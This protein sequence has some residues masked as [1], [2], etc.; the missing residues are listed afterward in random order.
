M[1]DARPQDAILS[2][3]GPCELEIDKIKGSRFLGYAWPVSS[4]EA[5]LEE[6]E[7]VRK[8][9]HYARH[10]CWAWRGADENQH[11]AF[12]AGEPRSSAGPPILRAIEGFELFEVG[13]LVL[14]Y[15]GGT[16]LGI[17]GLIRAYG[18]CARQVLETARVEWRTRTVLLVL[19]V[20]P[21]LI[22][23][24]H[25]CLLSMGIRPGRPN[26]AERVELKIEVAQ[27]E[28]AQ[29]ERKLMDAC[30]GR[31]EIERVMDPGSD[32]GDTWHT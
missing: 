24:V 4:L 6:I 27:R 29:I 31:I 19:R 25:G 16:K 30:S 11:R 1:R 2:L 28:V 7:C 17:G 5:L 20:A 9:H 21:A 22:G 32:E 23:S 3:A 15:F 8:A 12:D 18:G 26:F 13:V 10:L 14:R